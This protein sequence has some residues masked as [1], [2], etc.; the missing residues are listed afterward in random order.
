MPLHSRGANHTSIRSVR[1]TA[2]SFGKANSSRSPRTT[3][4][5]NGEPTELVAV[6]ESGGAA[7]TPRSSRWTLRKLESGTRSHRGHGRGRVFVAPTPVCPP[8]SF[9]VGCLKCWRG[10]RQHPASGIG[11]AHEDLHPQAVPRRPDRPQRVGQEHVRPQALPAD[12]GAVVGRLPGDGQRRREQPGRHRRGVRRAPL[13][14]RQAAGARA[15]DRGRCHQRPARGPQAAGRAGPQ[16]PL[17]AGR[18]RARICPRSSARSGTAPGRP[19]VRPARHPQPAVATAAVAARAAAGGLPPRL[20]ARKRR[21][22]SRRRSSSGCRCGTTARTS[23]ARSTSSATFTAAPTNWRPAG[24]A[25]LRRGRRAER[26][27]G[28]G[29]RLRPP[30]GPQGG[31]R[32]RPGGP[33]AAGPRHAAARAQHGRRRLG[34]LR[35]GQPRHEAAARSSAAGTCRSRTAWPSRSP[36]STPCRTTCGQPSQS[37]WPSSSTAW[38]ATTSSTAASWWSPTPG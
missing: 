11:T 18:H 24:A 10:F 28:W 14:R 30:R 21:R 12:G 31:V 7:S 23:T 35:A 15:A 36:R 9:T 29:N 4:T 37:R 32:R 27:P 22:R 26:R 2:S 33:R 38:S 19:R 25:G 6:R 3:T 16:V 5:E 13:H 8:P 1:S 34:A 17:P 20:R